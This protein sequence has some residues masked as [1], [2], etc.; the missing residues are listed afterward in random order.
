MLVV[1]NIVRTYFDPVLH[2]NRV[3]IKYAKNSLKLIFFKNIF[4]YYS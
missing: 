1:F 3:N 4:Y 2:K